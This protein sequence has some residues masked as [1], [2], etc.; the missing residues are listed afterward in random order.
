[1]KYW[2]KLS[3][4]DKMTESYINGKN[5]YPIK[6]YPETAE[7]VEDYIN[8]PLSD[9]WFV[10]RFGSSKIGDFASREE[11]EKELAAVLGED[12]YCRMH[13]C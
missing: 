6:L 7:I 2:Y 13:D 1:M 11:A 12:I 10:P 9:W 3:D 4:K 8:N 5:F